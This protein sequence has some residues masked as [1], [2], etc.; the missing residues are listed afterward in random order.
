MIF[1]SRVQYIQLRNG[2]GDR[3]FLIN[4]LFRSG[5]MLLLF[6][7]QIFKA[8]V[9]DVDGPGGLGFYQNDPPAP[10]GK[11]RSVLMPVTRIL[12]KVTLVS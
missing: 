4:I 1:F 7:Y 10:D 5:K 6:A 9:S 8:P 11:S 12:L 3:I 2:K